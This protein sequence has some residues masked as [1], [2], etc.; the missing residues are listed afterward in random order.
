MLAGMAQA[1]EL[2]GSLFDMPALPKGE[3]KKLYVPINTELLQAAL[4]Q[5]AAAEA[6][7]NSPQLQQETQPDDGQF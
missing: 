6:A 4:A 7:A 2:R 5:V 3:G 1:D